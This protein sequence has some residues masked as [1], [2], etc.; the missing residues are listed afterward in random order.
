M[1]GVAQGRFE[2]ALKRCERMLA[3]DPG[4]SNAIFV[5]AFALQNLGKDDE[6]IAFYR[7]YLQ[8]R[9]DD[10]QGWFDL[11][12]ALMHKEEYREA[13][14]CFERVLELKPGVREAHMHLVDCYEKLGDSK[15]ASRHRMFL[16][17]R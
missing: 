11:G 3:V 2:D 10:F 12:Y 7:S 17:Q 13:V 4:Y 14:K 9:P 8:Y 5:K 1:D 15:A 6:A 16:E